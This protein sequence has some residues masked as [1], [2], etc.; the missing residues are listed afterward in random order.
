[1]HRS[2]AV[3]VLPQDFRPPPEASLAAVLRIDRR[4]EA[5]RRMEAGR[6][7]LADLEVVGDEWDLPERAAAV[8]TRFGLGHLPL[9]RPVGAMGGEATRVALAGLAMHSTRSRA[10]STHT[11]VRCSW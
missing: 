8:L 6:S 10:P 9:D 4:L 3:A 11:M 7:T 1:M 2:G 5:L